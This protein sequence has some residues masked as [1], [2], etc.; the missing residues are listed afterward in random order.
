MEDLTFWR[1]SEKDI[2]DSIKNKILVLP[3]DT[4]IYPGHGEASMIVDEKALYI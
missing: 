2:M 4:M 1:G 3:D